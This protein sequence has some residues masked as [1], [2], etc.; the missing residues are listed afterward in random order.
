[1]LAKLISVRR[2]GEGRHVTEKE[3]RHI[4]ELCKERL[5]ESYGSMI[6]IWLVEMEKVDAT[7]LKISRDYHVE[8]FCEFIVQA[9]YYQVCTNI[10]AVRSD[11]CVPWLEIV[12]AS[13]RH[14]DPSLYCRPER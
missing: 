4:M 12:V 1:V 5:Y 10:V 7:Y 9:K 3:L 11:A 14:S 2:F 6:P 8:H 13:S